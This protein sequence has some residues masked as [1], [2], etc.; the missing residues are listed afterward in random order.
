[1]S[2]QSGNSSDFS[3]RERPK[4][5]SP[6]IDSRREVAHNQGIGEAGTASERILSASDKHKEH[7][8][9]VW[10]GGQPLT[11]KAQK[12]LKSLSANT[13]R[14]SGT[15]QRKLSKRNGKANSALVSSAA[16]YYVALKKLADG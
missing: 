7:I 6:N 5:R 1:M 4:K 15:V 8:H 9:L 3:N 16:K 10:R 2:G 14:Y 11:Q 13:K 12:S